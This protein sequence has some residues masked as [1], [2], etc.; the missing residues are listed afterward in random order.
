LELVKENGLVGFCSWPTASAETSAPSHIAAL[1]VNSHDGPAQAYHNDD[2]GRE[3][4]VSCPNL[5]LC[6]QNTYEPER[7]KNIFFPVHAYWIAGG[8]KK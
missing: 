4:G 6:Y 1:D 3:S 8:G 2:R 5:Q 7:G